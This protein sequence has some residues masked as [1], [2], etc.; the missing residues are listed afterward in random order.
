MHHAHLTIFILCSNERA[1]MQGA[2]GVIIE[3]FTMAQQRSLL[4][5]G[6]Y[7]VGFRQANGMVHFLLSLM[8]NALTPQDFHLV[9][10]TW[11]VLV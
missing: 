6:G 1:D 8:G 3:A 2:G 7:H 9:T 11:E 10:L 4:L 5:P